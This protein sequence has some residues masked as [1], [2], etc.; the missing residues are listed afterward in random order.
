MPKAC[1]ALGLSPEERLHEVAS[2]LARGTARWRLEVKACRDMHDAATGAASGIGLEQTLIWLVDGIGP[3]W[4][5]VIW[6]SRPANHKSSRE[7]YIGA[8]LPG[9]GPNRFHTLCD[10]REWALPGLTRPDKFVLS[11]S[12]DNRQE[13]QGRIEL[14]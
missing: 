8:R 12:L 4:L 2:I 9:A 6:P 13:G 3:T 11:P 5:S 7:R 10:H 14:R 1:P